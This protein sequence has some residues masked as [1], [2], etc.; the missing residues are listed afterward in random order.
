[1]CLLLLFSS[2]EA[3]SLLKKLEGKILQLV[4]KT[5]S[6]DALK[7]IILSTQYD[8]CGGCMRLNGE[9]TGFFHL[10]RIDGI[11]WLIDPVGNVFLS[12]G[13]NH[14]SFEGDYAPTLG[15]SP[16]NRVV[17]AKYGNA[18]SW[19][20]E[21]V[22]K[23]RNL[24]FNTI[25]AWSSE[26]TLSKGMP[27]TLV[28][29]I[30]SSAGSDW[31]SGSVADFFSEKFEEVADEIAHK[32]CYTRRDDPYLI[33]YFT[34]NELRW[35]PDWRSERHLF[36]DYLS[37]P[38][39]SPGKKALVKFLEEKYLE[40]DAL[41]KAWNESFS[42]FND[43]LNIR[44]IRDVSKLD[45]DRS[46]F[47]EVVSAR[48][49]KVCYEAIRRY[50]KRH[51]ILGCRYATKPPDEVLKGCA[52][53]FDLIS[54]NNYSKEPPLEEF[55]K[56]YEL[57]GLP[58]I[59]TEFSFKAM[60]SG[61]PNTKGAGVPLK[62]QKER[63]DHYERYV[64]ELLMET[65]VVGYH[66]FQYT[67]EPAEGRFDGENSNFGIVKIDDE[68]WEILSDMVAAVNMVAELLHSE[69][70][71]STLTFYVSPQGDD[72]WSGR[73]PSPSESKTDGPFATI[74]KARDAI[75]EIKTREGHRKP[76]KVFIRGGTF[77]LD[78][79]LLFT[80]EDSG[81]DSCP[82]TYE[83][84]PGEVPILSGGAR[85]SGWKQITVQG[86]RLW[87]VQIPSVREEEWYF[88]EL[89]VDGK[90]RLRARHPNKGYLS[91]EEV[92]DAT[93]QTQWDEGQNRIRFREGDLKALNNVSDAEAIVMN[94]W[95]ES[96]LPIESLD[97]VNRILSFSKKS[98]FRLDPGDLYYIENSLELLDS[99][100]EWFLD[101]S[102]GTLYYYAM[103]D[104]DMNEAE[105]IAPFLPQLL[106]LQGDPK[107]GEF[108]HHITFK[109]ITFSHTE[110]SLPSTLSGFRQAAI[111][112]PAVLYGEGVRNCIIEGCIF[113]HI[114]TYA[115]EL[116][117]GC[118]DNK[119]H[120]C[121][122]YDLGAGGIKIGEQ[123]V[124]D[125]VE[126]QTHGNIISD[127]EIQD[128]GLI[129][130][131][132]V[133]IWIGQ[134]YENIIRNNH[135]CN[136][137]YTGISI[138]WTWGYGPSLARGNIVEL[139]HVQNIGIRSDGDGPIL[140]DMGGIYTLGVRSGTIIRS[141][142]FHDIAGFRYGG[143]GIYLDEG[144]SNVL[145]EKNIVYRTTHGGFH[146]HYG[147][148][149]IVRNN[150]FAF[151]KDA[152]IQRS[153]SEEHI[154]FTFER[155]IVYF[156]S[157]NVLA[158]NFEDANFS[159]DLNIYW[160][161]GEEVLFGKYSWE[162]WRDRGADLHS[163]I[164]DPLFLD[165][166]CGNFSLKKDSPAFSLGFEEIDTTKVG[167]R[168]SV[169]KRDDR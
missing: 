63:A 7:S 32:E 145:T 89:W 13:V 154:S 77:F 157:G 49:S 122:L 118:R 84:Y 100:G 19:A 169:S 25:G 36:D 57:T 55:R 52:R 10:E 107:T 166:D 101:H 114:G 17:S 87:V 38:P 8:E 5:R 41:N 136:F 121:E 143:W 147:R 50:D 21:T 106:K 90:R 98:V 37:M 129:F 56:I 14:V 9:T 78:E 128:G 155:N 96:H 74:A 15:Y 72:R 51:L 71:E 1:M 161:Q 137:Y 105:V 64:K 160:R 59:V 108:L 149:N 146:Q 94:R 75:R 16:Y 6:I 138:G 117:R 42:S 119:I 58:L 26:E 92:P 24:G 97:E 113:A 152:Q 134:S 18:E 112:V 34:D 80:A 54:I 53:Y 43:I 165:P 110:W 164:A 48:Y 3:Y 124:R 40:I 81:T 12:K 123:L 82:I 83:S 158:G 159:F 35:S 109:G 93:P 140:S 141:N 116:S 130:H 111:G 65:Y 168:I 142:I 104:E 131:S 46:D 60:D 127:C 120:R 68:P 144:S 70:K 156:R 99:P 27:Y 132:A 11:W 133:G 61:L 162:A 76:I 47:L 73:L 126:E 20:K 153:R 115:I 39:E 22:K 102:T 30:A 79:P 33:G 135:I 62:T 85:I 95:V 28:L 2:I 148:E 103:P 91:I 125:E 150:I 23:L 86:K 69:S 66:W 163:L 88:R 167:P 44:S 67:D 45:Q 4:E 139:N 29:N 31:V 151:G